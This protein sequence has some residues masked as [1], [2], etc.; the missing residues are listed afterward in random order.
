MPKFED[1]AVSEIFNGKA[2]PPILIRP[3]DKMFRTRIRQGAAKGSN[4]AGHYSIAEWGCGSECLSLAVINAKTGAVY[5]APF[6]YVGWGY[7]DLRYE[8][9]FSPFEDE[10]K[11]TDYNLN[12]RLLII[13][14][15]P[16]DKN[17]AS[18][19]YEWTG[20]NF[21]LLRKVPAVPSSTQ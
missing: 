16:E 7:P 18:Y 13:R 2:A 8:G 11:P 6:P 14:G 3:Q 21:K 5:A 12:S 1:Y 17:C 10:F 4:F 20:Q 15:C 9:R 19:F